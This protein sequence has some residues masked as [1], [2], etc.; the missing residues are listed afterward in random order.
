[1]SDYRRPELLDGVKVVDVVKDLVKNYGWEGLA[2]EFDYRCL[3]MN[4]SVLSFHK[5]LQANEWARKDVERYYVKHLKIMKI[6]E[7]LAN[8]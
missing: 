3:T 2:E 8:Q 1:M 7:E 5:F 4:P 6:R